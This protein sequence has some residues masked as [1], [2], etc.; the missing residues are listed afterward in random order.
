MLTLNLDSNPAAGNHQN[1]VKARSAWGMPARRVLST[2]NALDEMHDPDLTR[3]LIDELAANGNG[4]P[5]QLRRRLTAANSA[6]DVYYSFDLV[7]SP[8]T[9]AALEDYVRPG[10]GTKTAAAVTDRLVAREYEVLDLRGDVVRGRKA[11]Q[12]LRRG[13]SAAEEV[14]EEDDGFELV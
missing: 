3:S 7:D 5:V 4:G 8:A 2:R 10:S 1:I 12:S 9:K 11:R 6:P 13:E 14:P